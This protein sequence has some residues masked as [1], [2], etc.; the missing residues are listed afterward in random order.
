[1]Q[2]TELPVPAYPMPTRSSESRF[3]AEFGIL[4]EDIKKLNYPDDT[5]LP[6]YEIQLR[7]FRLETPA[8]QQDAFPPNTTVCLDDA[9]VTLPV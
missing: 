4:P 8:E 5:E 1:M 7:V 9:V 2:M 3:S 6:R